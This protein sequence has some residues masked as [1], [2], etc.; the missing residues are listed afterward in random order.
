MFD[1]ID[2]N[3]FSRF[4]KYVWLH[5]GMLSK[6]ILMKFIN[7]D[8]RWEVSLHEKH[9]SVFT[10]AAVTHRN[11]TVSGVAAFSSFSNRNIILGYPKEWESYLTDSFKL[12]TYTTALSKSINPF[13][14]LKSIS[15]LL[16]CFYSKAL[17]WS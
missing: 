7:R 16:N 9:L 12:R 13:S 15:Q 2:W 3:L 11:I 5:A 10:Q 17:I 8:Y 4:C 6:R 14:I 1:F